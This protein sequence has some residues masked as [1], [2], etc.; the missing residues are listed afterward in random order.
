MAG[1]IR[2]QAR[3]VNDSRIGSDGWFGGFFITLGGFGK[4]STA[5]QLSV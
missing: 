4:R 2:A 5:K 3:G 1:A